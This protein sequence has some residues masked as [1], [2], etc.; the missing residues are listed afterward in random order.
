MIAQKVK[1]HWPKSVA[2]PSIRGHALDKQRSL[3]EE[4]HDALDHI[5]LLVL[6]CSRMRMLHDVTSFYPC[7]SSSLAV[8]PTQC[9]V[10]LF[11]LFLCFF[12]VGAAWYYMVL[13]PVVFFRVLGCRKRCCTLMEP[14]VVG[15]G[16]NQL[17]HAARVLP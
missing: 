6:E 13:P 15:V 16:S 12:G 10:A 14:E 2:E 1:A 7:C 3:G 9:H 8:E 17:R 4:L 11:P 5:W